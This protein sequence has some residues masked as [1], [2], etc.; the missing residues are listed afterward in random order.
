MRRRRQVWPGGLD[1]DRLDLL[2]DRLA[3][4]DLPSDS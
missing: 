1:D 4:V 3:E 2:L